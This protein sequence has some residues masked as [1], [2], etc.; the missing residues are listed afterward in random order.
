MTAKEQ[1][2]EIAAEQAVHDESRMGPASEHEYQSWLGFMPSIVDALLAHPDL[3]LAVLAETG[4]L[5]EERG[6]TPGVSRPAGPEECRYMSPWVPSGD[7][8]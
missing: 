7:Q 5:T 8:T 3:L 6:F 4:V 2:A 1:L